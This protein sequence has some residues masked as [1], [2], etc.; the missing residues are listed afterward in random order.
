VRARTDESEST[1]EGSTSTVSSSSATSSPTG[2]VAAMD[3]SDTPT[4]TVSVRKE[5]LSHQQHFSKVASRFQFDN[6]TASYTTWTIQF[7]SEIEGYT[8]DLESTLTTLGDT[9]L[10]VDMAR[11]K[12]VYHMIL[13]CVPKAI[14][15]SLTT[16]PR[17]QHTGYH[18]WATLRRQ[19]LGDEATYLQTLETQFHRLA[20]ADGEQFP[21]FEL[22]FDQILGELAALGHAKTDHVKRATLMNAIETSNKRDVRRA[23]VFDRF[24]VVSKIHAKDSFDEWLVHI[25]VEAQQIRDAIAGEVGSQ[26]GV[27]RDGAED[28]LPVSFVTPSTPPSNRPPPLRA[29]RRGDAIC[30]NMQN[31]GACSFGARCKFSH[32]LSGAKAQDGM[33]S[34]PL[35]VCNNFLAGRCKWGAKCRRTHPSSSMPRREGVQA[36]AEPLFRLDAPGLDHPFDPQSMA[37]PS[38][39]P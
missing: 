5:L 33:P 24:N 23:H 14:L 8:H 4:S 36:K 3:V 15:A 26:R 22:R 31:T 27:K 18:A 19:F 34:S 16:P 20:W 32:D 35:E 37:H 25:R 9:Q 12:T 6:T 17:Q 21:A 30:F 11:Q 38:R 7:Q 2:A 1:S 39:Q 28:T 29:A 13:H 10:E